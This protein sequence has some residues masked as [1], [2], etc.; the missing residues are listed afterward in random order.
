MQIIAKEMSNHD[1]S[2]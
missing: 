1:R 2:H